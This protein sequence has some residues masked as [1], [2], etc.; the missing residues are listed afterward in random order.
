[1]MTTR[2]DGIIR[3]EPSPHRLR[4]ILLKASE[5]IDSQLNAPTCTPLLREHIF[6]NFMI[7]VTDHASCTRTHITTM[8]KQRC[9]NMSS[10]QRHVRTLFRTRARR[11]LH[12]T[13]QQTRAHAVWTDRQKI[14]PTS[15]NH[16]HTRGG[17]RR[18]ARQQAH[19]RVA[20]R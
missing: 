9:T 7:Y 1:M 10:L 3:S 6:I 17:S 11:Q 12:Q 16:L 20:G 15:R 2:G 19:C 14:E 18:L 13:P 5:N 8:F 4:W